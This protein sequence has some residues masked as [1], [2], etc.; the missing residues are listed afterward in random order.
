MNRIAFLTVVLLGLILSGCKTQQKTMGVNNDDVYYQTSPSQDYSTPAANSTAPQV[1]EGTDETADTKPKAAAV[2]EDVNDYSYSARVKRFHDPVKDAGYFD[3]A[4]TDASNYDTTAAIAG[5]GSSGDPD[6]NIYLGAGYGGYWGPYS[7]FGFSFGW[8]YDPWYYGYPYSYWYSPSY[9]WDPFYF[10]YCCYPYYYPYY[11]YGGYWNGYYNGYWDGY[12]GYPYGWNGYGN[13]YYP[14]GT[15]YGHRNFG[16]SGT[17]GQPGRVLPAETQRVAPTGT[18]RINPA[19]SPR[20]APAN[21]TAT[22]TSAEARTVPNSQQQYRYTRPSSERQAPVQ[23]QNTGYER[24]KEQTPPRYARPETGQQV[25]STRSN[26]QNYTSPAYRQPKSSQEYLSPR[27]QPSTVNRNEGGTY[28]RPSATQQR[29]A[30]P[31]QSGTPRGYSTPGNSQGR[32]STP[33]VSPSQ[34]QNSNSSSPQRI[35]TP[36]QRSNQNYSSPSRSNSGN[37]GYSAPSRSSGGSVS[38]PSRS[39]SG[40]GSFSSPSRSS[41]GGGGGSMGGHRK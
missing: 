16:G 32:T 27:S 20:V 10:G 15:Y 36:A 22:R 41:G 11:S 19:E 26:P 7:S 8:G 4:Y 12:Y 6:V 5:G 18:P 37:S 35:S 23:R 33:A 21:I 9:W 24:Q 28:T 34:R 38:S 29:Q 14:G 17:V 40:G 31:A 13:E 25:Q 3:P 1:I 39:G 2:T 30:T